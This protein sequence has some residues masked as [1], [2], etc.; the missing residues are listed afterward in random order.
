MPLD[1]DIATADHRQRY[2]ARHRVLVVAVTVSIWRV[3]PALR[4]VTLSASYGRP[5]IVWRLTWLLAPVGPVPG[6]NRIVT[7][8]IDRSALRIQ[9]SPVGRIVTA[10]R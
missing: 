9:P 6:G 5:Q 2:T 1:G 3:S 10:L 7:R 8:S 4:F